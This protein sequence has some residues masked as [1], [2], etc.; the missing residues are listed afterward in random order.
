MPVATTTRPQPRLIRE[1]CP[2][3]A[4]FPSL[5][6]DMMVFIAPLGAT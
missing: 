5:D 1:F 3:S 6:F 4:A 2:T